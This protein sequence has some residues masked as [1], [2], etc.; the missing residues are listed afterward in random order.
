MRRDDPTRLERSPAWPG[1]GRLTA[2]DLR[3]AFE[4]PRPPTVGAE[5]ELMLLDP[6][7]LELAACSEPV[8]S[9]TEGDPRF[10]HELREAQIELVAQPAAAVPELIAGMAAARAFLL[11]RIAGRVL[12]AAAGTH[13]FS[14]EW[15][16]VSDAPRYR[17]L[18][19]EYTWPTRGAVPCGL[20]VHVAVDADV[21]LDA[22]NAA[23]SSVP[24][25]GALAA[26]SPF[27]DGQET[28][29]SMIRPKLNEA[30]PRTG[31]PPAFTSWD[32]LAA[33][34]DWGRSAGLFPDPSHL[35]WDLRLHPGHGTLELRV[36]D[37]QS[38]LAD[39]AAVAAIFQCLVSD[40]GDRL[41]AGEP[42]PVHP[43]HRIRE[44]AWRAARYGVRGHFADLD[45]GTPVAVRDLV[46]EL[47][48]RLTPAARRLGC[49]HE[50]LH[51]SSL[52]VGNGADRQLEI[53]RREG[54]RALVRHLVHETAHDA[55]E[56]RLPAGRP[57]ARSGGVARRRS[58]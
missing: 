42:V 8:L 18:V 32:E 36:A 25:L 57:G 35:W 13:P 15:G 16:A 12:V 50:L 5:E 26:N 3:A 39:A 4:G 34:V 43:S 56:I 38:R 47:V 31:T 58:G 49:E 2:A 17:Q 54:M 11:E 52:V 27:L 21:A 6:G 24:L 40:L 53:A 7:T 46:L 10:T 1:E 20:H 29:L 45:T 23:R 33:Y 28:G 37:A 22:F 48:E 55:V 9:W 51:A 44:N 41:R 30:L 14:T 19:A